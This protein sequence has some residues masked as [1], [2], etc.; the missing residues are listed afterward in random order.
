MT[1]VVGKGQYFKENSSL[2][3]NSF[4]HNQIFSCTK[5]QSKTPPKVKRK[6][7]LISSRMTKKLKLI[8]DS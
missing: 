4:L 8:P 3:Q 7:F 5:Y 1:G 6:E 2:Q